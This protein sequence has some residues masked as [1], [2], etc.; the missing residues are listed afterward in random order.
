MEKDFYVVLELTRDATAE[1]IRSAFRRRALELHPD[2]AGAA[3]NHVAM[4]DESR[5]D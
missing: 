3:C 4:V 5:N 2:R 1:Q